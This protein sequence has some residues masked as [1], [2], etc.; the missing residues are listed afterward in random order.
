MNWA[1]QRRAER[2]ARKAKQAEFQPL[3]DLWIARADALI[4]SVLERL[5]A[6]NRD[7]W[8]ARPS[9]AGLPARR[10][11]FSFEDHERLGRELKDVR[12]AINDVLVG[13]LP[14]TRQ[15]GSGGTFLWNKTHPTDRALDRAERRIDSLRS[16]LEDLLC[17]D[18]PELGHTR[19]YY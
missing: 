11:I 16:R 10:R 12:G 17:R 15:P 18:W 13:C 9:N 3:A 1:A 7:S 6:Q 8:G 19:V 5:P 2:E 4:Q 14:G